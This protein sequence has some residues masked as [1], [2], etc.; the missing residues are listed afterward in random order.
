MLFVTSLLVRC[1][2]PDVLQAGESDLSTVGQL[3]RFVFL[4]NFTGHPAISLPAG[5]NSQGSVHVFTSQS[6][7]HLQLFFLQSCAPTYPPASHN[8]QGSVHGS[9]SQS[10]S[11]RQLLL[12]QSCAPTYLSPCWSQ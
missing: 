4:S 9:T 11:F 12:L 5:H 2:R 8:R 10:I 7:R 3:M 1:C 6:I